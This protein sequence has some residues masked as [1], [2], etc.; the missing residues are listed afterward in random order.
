MHNSLDS[1]KTASE[2]KIIDSNEGLLYKILIISFN[3]FSS[4]INNA[5]KLILSLMLLLVF[6][7][8]PRL[9]LLCGQTIRMI[10]LPYEKQLEVTYLN[11]NGVE[12][13]I[14]GNYYIENNSTLY[15]SNVEW[16]LETIKPLTYHIK[17]IV[18][19]SHKGN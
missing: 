2:A 11:Q 15:V 12:S 9:S 7:S 3:I 10:N 13:K 6:V 17:P 16:Q 5:F 18:S 19:N 8:T 1:K 14:S 4:K